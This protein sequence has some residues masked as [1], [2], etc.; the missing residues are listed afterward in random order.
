MDYLICI[1]LRICPPINPWS[2]DSLPPLVVFKGASFNSKYLPAAVIDL[3]TNWQWTTTNT[4]WSNDTLTFKWMT[5]V[6]EPVTATDNAAWRLLIVDGQ[7]SHVK[8]PFIAFC[9]SHLIDLMILPSHLLHKT[10]PLDVGIFGPLKH[11]LTRETKCNSRYNPGRTAKADW[12]AK[13]C[14]C[15]SCSNDKDKCNC[16]LEIYRSLSVLPRSSN[17]RYQYPF[18]TSA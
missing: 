4:G 11:H 14:L 10:Q 6:F 15:S 3:V 7:S 2:L 12:A 1:H 8:A 9:I 18:Y 5:H 17:V 13:P 16:W